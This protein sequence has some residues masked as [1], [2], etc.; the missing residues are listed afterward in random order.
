MKQPKPV[1]FYHVTN[2]DTADRI[3][4]NGFESADVRNPGGGVSLFESP[5]D[6]RGEAALRVTIPLEIAARMEPYV[7]RDGQG[8]RRWVV[9]LEI[10][11]HAEVVRLEGSPGS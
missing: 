1:V 9:P 4:A 6:G 5:L 10:A 7:L 11:R 2:A 3:L 8:G